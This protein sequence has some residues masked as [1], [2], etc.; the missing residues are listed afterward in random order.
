MKIFLR[1]NYLSIL[2]LLCPL[3]YNAPLQLFCFMLRFLNYANDKSPPTRIYVKKEFFRAPR[4]VESWN[5][6]GAKTKPL[7][8][9]VLFSQRS[10]KHH[11]H[12]YFDFVDTGTKKTKAYQNDSKPNKH[13][14]NHPKNPRSIE[15][16]MKMPKLLGSV[17]KN[18]LWQRLLH[19]F[20]VTLLSSTIT[21]PN[22][23]PIKC[24]LF[25]CWIFYYSK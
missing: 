6:D 11:L 3:A 16:S 20:C 19:L 24:P 9:T 21:D 23:V 2:A 17:M 15:K 12:F 8:V 10:C 4:S 7:L 13:A 5:L 18:S 22:R 25:E 14:E 1:P